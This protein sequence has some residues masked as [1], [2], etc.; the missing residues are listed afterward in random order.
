LL[1]EGKRPLGGT[2]DVWH[3]IKMGLKEKGRDDVDWVLRV[4][5]RGK[6]KVSYER[7]S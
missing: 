4:E 6:G 3:N 5:D 2:S 7:V 1:P